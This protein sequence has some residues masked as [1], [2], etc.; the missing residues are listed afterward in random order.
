MSKNKHDIMRVGDIWLLNY[1]YKT[2]GNMEKTR[3]GI[4]VGFLD[5]DKVL[6]QKITTKGR[7]GKNKLIDHPKLRKG[8]YL[9]YEKTAIPDYD[10]LRYIG[11]TNRRVKE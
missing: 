5:D 9:S 4:I 2:P 8:S 7:G 3:P 10:L 11:N 6:V 1:P